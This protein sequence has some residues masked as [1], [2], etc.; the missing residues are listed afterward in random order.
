MVISNPHVKLGVS[1]TKSL[2]VQNGLGRKIKLT[3][4]I[5]T[6]RIFFHSFQTKIILN[7][8]PVF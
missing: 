8:W 6:A 3:R 1:K 2:E 5:L 7:R 4:P